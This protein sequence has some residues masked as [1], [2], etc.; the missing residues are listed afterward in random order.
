VPFGVVSNFFV[1]LG[2]QSNAQVYQNEARTV[3]VTPKDIASGSR[4]RPSKTP[5]TSGAGAIR[6]FGRS[7]NVAVAAAVGLVLILWAWIYIT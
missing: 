6:E 3:C 4:V 5:W 2:S 7:T 1:R